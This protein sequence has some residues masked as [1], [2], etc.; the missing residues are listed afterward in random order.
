MAVNFVF[1]RCSTICPPMGAAFGRLQRKLAKRPDLEVDLIS[2]S[3]DPIHDT[4]ERLTRWADRFGREEGWTLLTG[5]KPDIDQV[6][7]A[8]D[9]FTPDKFEHAALL[10]IGNPETGRWTRIDG[11]AG[12]KETIAALESLK[13]ETVVATAT[14]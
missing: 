6:L 1:T 8:M 9:A 13:A 12:P 14:R 11:L 4:P 2:V 10:L 5:A 7:R 3:I